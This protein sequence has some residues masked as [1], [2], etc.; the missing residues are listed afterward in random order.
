MKQ[1][2]FIVIDGIDGSGKTTILLK[3]HNYLFSKSKRIRILTTN[4]PTSGVN[5]MKA[6]E[7]ILNESDPLKNAE[8]CLTLF[9]DDRKDHLENLIK[10]FLKKIAS[11]RNHNPSKPR[12]KK[13]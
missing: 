1:S 13:N 12:K 5:G 9:S 8:K 10:P 7:I 4:E 2:L 6:R 11:Q 3:I